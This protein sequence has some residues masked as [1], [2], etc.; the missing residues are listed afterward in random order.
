MAQMK[1]I[2]EK[3]PKAAGS[4]SALEKG[5][6]RDFRETDTFRRSYERLDLPAEP[7]GCGAP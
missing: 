7:S 5:R 1:G 6:A 4:R 3:V 2:E